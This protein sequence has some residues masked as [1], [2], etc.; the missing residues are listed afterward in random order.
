MDPNVALEQ[1]LTA[2]TVEE[3]EEVWDDLEFW[4]SN[5]GAEPT[6]V[7]ECESLAKFHS[8]WND[9]DGRLGDPTERE[10]DGLDY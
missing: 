6:W 8:W 10:S 3:S 2:L 9:R 7:P 4:L 1:F 5:G